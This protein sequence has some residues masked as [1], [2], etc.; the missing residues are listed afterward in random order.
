MGAKITQNRSKLYKAS[1]LR[2]PESPIF[3]LEYYYLEALDQDQTPL[4]T[5]AWTSSL[6]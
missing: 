1:V 4:Q 6:S 5:T 2:V 3:F